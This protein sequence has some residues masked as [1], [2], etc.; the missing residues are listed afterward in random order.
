MVRLARALARVIADIASVYPAMIREL[1]PSK[2]E[3]LGTL[4]PYS[5]RSRA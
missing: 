3:D 2:A 5:A 4:V 1:R